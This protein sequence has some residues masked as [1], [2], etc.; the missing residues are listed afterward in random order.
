M[1]KY[2]D[3]QWK[4]DRQHSQLAGVC[5]GFAKRYDQSVGMIR[6]LTVV[7]FVCFPVAVLIAYGIA[8]VALPR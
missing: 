6:L 7:L 3:D 8:A 5:A 4:L 1:K 2:H